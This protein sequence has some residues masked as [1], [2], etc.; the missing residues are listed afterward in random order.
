MNGL[1]RT[2][3]GFICVLLP[4]TAPAAMQ[5]S[6]AYNLNGGS[7]ISGGGATAAGSGVR[8]SGAVIGQWAAIPAA[9]AASSNYTTT[10]LLLASPQ[11]G[12][13]HSGDINGDG[14][15]DMIDAL[16]ALHAQTGLVA[17]TEQEAGRGDVGPLVNNVPLGNGRID[18]DDTVLILRKAVGMSW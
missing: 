6:P 3:L 14:R 12:G 5:S 10:A 1:M 8:I 7:I 13:I 11:P 17:L 16:M 15:V 4:Q 2:M 18:I 9:G